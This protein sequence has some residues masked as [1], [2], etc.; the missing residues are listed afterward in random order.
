MTIISEIP[1]PK[2]ISLLCSVFI[3]LYPFLFSY[4][5][6]IIY[7]VFSLPYILK[8][9]C[10]FSPVFVVSF[11][12]FTAFLLILTNKTSVQCSKNELGFVPND[13]HDVVDKNLP[14]IDKEDGEFYPLEALEFYNT[15]FEI[16]MIDETDNNNVDNSEELPEEKILQAVESSILGISQN[17]EECRRSKDETF[18]CSLKEDS[19]DDGHL[20]I[21][22]CV[23]KEKRFEEFLKE[24]D[25][26]EYM[27]VDKSFDK[28]KQEPEKKVNMD[29]MKVDKSFEKQKLEL[30]IVKSEPIKR[31]HSRRRSAKTNIDFTEAR[32]GRFSRKEKEWKK[33]LACKL[34]EEKHSNNIEG[35]EGM[36]LLWE[37]YEE[38]SSMG[39][40]RNA[41]NYEN[42]GQERKNIITGYF[43]DEE[44][45]DEEEIDVHVSCLHA[46]K[47]SGGKMN[48]G[49]GGRNLVR[50]SKVIKGIRWLRSVTKKMNNN[51]EKCQFGK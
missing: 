24:V 50:I 26:V 41:M 40:S 13:S 36:D 8:I 25:E 5:F 39:N 32:G 18:S 29:C 11:F 23:V 1:K 45:D 35:S 42:D 4:P 34:F 46:F 2:F 9:L 38:K 44:D 33:T 21:P 47:F 28:Q 22:K 43:E 30:E 3:F 10:F 6:L 49:V 15:V 51:E 19:F 14:R 37:T 7:L 20:E 48:M 16:F 27:E 17:N 12:L 31:R